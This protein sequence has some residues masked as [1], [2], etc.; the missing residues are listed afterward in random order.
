MRLSLKGEKMIIYTIPEY[1]KKRKL[2]KEY[3]ISSGIGINT[4]SQTP[5]PTLHLER[6]TRYFRHDAQ[7]NYIK[8]KSKKFHQCSL[9]RSHAGLI[10]INSEF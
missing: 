8:T 9:E 1:I 4:T 7:L 5:S 3:S 10:E 6:W 2:K